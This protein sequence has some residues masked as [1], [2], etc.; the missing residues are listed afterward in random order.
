MILA[1][2]LAAKYSAACL[3]TYTGKVVEQFDSWG[4]SEH[5]FIREVTEFWSAAKHPPPDVMIVEDLPHKL[6]FSTLIKRVC[7]IQ[8]RIIERM[9]VAGDYQDQVVF[10]QPSEWRRT[11]DG[12]GRGTGPDIVVPVAATFGYTPPDLSERA[13][14]K[15]SGGNTVAKKV[16]T[17]YCAAFLIARWAISQKLEYGTFDVPGTTRYGHAPIKKG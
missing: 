8:G 1:V 12:M 9:H 14:V 6:P 16:A 13:A 7:R 3:M 4:R 17:D 5:D 15:G 11:Y 10:L 2:D